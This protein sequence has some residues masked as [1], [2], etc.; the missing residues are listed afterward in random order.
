[1]KPEYDPE[2]IKAVAKEFAF[3][4]W[5][6]LY[7]VC[8]FVLAAYAFDYFFGFPLGRDATDPPSGRSG[9]KILVDNETGV[10]YLTTEKGGIIVRQKKVEK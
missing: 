4:L 3:Q 10:E 2:F 7:K 6:P 9:L 5:D 1:M 8:L